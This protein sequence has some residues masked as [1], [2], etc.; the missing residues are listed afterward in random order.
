M[1]PYHTSSSK[2]KYPEGRLILHNYSG[3]FL[4]VE[5]CTV[6]NISQKKTLP[7]LV[8]STKFLSIRYSIIKEYKFT[9]RVLKLPNRD[10]APP[11]R[12]DV[13][14]VYAASGHYNI[15]MASPGNDGM[16]W[17]NLPL[18]EATANVLAL[19]YIAANRIPLQRR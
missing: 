15:R 14:L 16:A 11:K 3:F 13:S 7:G 9:L 18:P 2:N 12:L 19:K 6:K 4:S 10:S 1:D 5:R 8:A 17:G